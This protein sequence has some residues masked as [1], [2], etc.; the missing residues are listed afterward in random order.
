M[1]ANQRCT[2]HVLR[3]L[4]HKCSHPVRFLPASVHFE[5]RHTR[6]CDGGWV[7]P[8]G[9]EFGL[10]CRA[11]LTSGSDRACWDISHDEQRTGSFPLV[12]I[13]LNEGCTREVK[14]KE[15]TLVWRI[16]NRIDGLID[17]SIR[18]LS[19]VSCTVLDSVLGAEVVATGGLI[20]NSRE[21]RRSGSG[22]RCFRALRYIRFL[23]RP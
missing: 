14:G 9:H 4:L 5:S 13:H 6:Q 1:D 23:A 20:D 8:S 21:V 17:R 16:A 3:T 19:C 10:L 18:C 7:R 11:G 15:G 2:Y 12:L 22:L